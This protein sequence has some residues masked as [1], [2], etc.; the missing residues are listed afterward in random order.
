MK[1]LVFLFT[2]LSLCLSQ[3]NVKELSFSGVLNERKSEISGLAWYKNNLIILPQYPF[4]SVLGKDALY[5]IDK[6]DLSNAI[7]NDIQLSPKELTLTVSD[8]DKKIDGFEGF[9]SIVFHGNVVFVTIEA[10]HNGKMSSYLIKGNIKSDLSELVLN[11]Q[12][13]TLI[14]ISH[15]LKNMSYESIMIYKNEIF[16]FFEANGKNVNSD[17]V[18]HCFDLNLNYLRSK[19]I[20]QI[21]YRITDVTQPKNDHFWAINYMWSGENDLLKPENPSKKSIEKLV[22][23]HISNNEIKLKRTIDLS[24]SKKSHNW[25]GLVHFDDKGFII[26][27]DKYPSSIIGFIKH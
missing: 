4:K 7:E 15:Q 19:K 22:Q 14:P 27:T 6:S 16:V 13:L 12:T 24:V 17:P 3:L 8:L 2:T 21:D 23:F 20:D 11:E 5:T 1:H 10:N 9:E 25:E 18:V 26:A